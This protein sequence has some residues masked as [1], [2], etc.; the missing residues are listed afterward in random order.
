M[1]SAE[2]DFCK[3]CNIMKYLDVG[4]Y[5]GQCVKQG[6]LKRESEG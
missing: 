6:V 1:N 2:I 3:G 4:G 5:C